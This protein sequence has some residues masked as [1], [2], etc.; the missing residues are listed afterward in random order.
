[1]YKVKICLMDGR[2]AKLDVEKL[3]DI[4][5]EDGVLAVQVS[6]SPLAVIYH[7]LHN[8]AWWRL[9]EQKDGDND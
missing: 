4:Q 7:P 1:M 8:V 5:V 3:E 9:D 6:V 2:L